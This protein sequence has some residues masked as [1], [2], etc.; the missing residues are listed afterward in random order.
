MYSSINFLHAQDA[1][2]IS[3][4]VCGPVVG[5]KTSIIS[6]RYGIVRGSRNS[7]GIDE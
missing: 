6:C 3:Y 2:H 7:H 1:V 5:M 4:Y